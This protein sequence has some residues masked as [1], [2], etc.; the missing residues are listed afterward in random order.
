MKS[1]IRVGIENDN[2]VI[3]LAKLA[4]KDRELGEIVEEILDRVLNPAYQR[5]QLIQYAK[6]VRLK[7]ADIWE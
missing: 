2:V 4:G 6:D 5:D 1:N 3:S 7:C